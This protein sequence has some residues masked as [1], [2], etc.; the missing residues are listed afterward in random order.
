MTTE[1]LTR[2]AAQAVEFFERKLAFETGPV[3]VKYALENKE[4]VQIVDLR[5]PELFAKGHVPTAINLLF[6]DLEN[7]LEKLS[8]DK[9][10]IVYCYNITCHLSAKAALLLAKKGYPVKEMIGGY[11]EWEAAE[12]PVETKGGSCSSASCG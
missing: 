12:L 2:E 11:A 9:T 6:E 7:K 5:R 3:G 8:K 4:P 1:T 10:T